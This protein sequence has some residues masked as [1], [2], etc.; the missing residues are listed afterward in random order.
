MKN[1]SIQNLNLAKNGITDQCLA[2]IK[3]FAENQGSKIQLFLDSN[4][5]SKK[6]KDILQVYQNILL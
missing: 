4:K 3:G 2:L 6:S 5:L 1:I